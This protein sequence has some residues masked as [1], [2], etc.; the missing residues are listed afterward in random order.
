MLTVLSNASLICFFAL[1]RLLTL[2]LDAFHTN[3]ELSRLLTCSGLAFSKL[4]QQIKV[5]QAKYVMDPHDNELRH[6]RSK[7]GKPTQASVKG[8]RH[9]Q[10]SLLHHVSFEILC[11]LVSGREKKV[12]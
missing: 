8:S 4:C 3:A 12:D 6:K 11:S 2:V 7:N 9:S 1:R 5:Q 10:T